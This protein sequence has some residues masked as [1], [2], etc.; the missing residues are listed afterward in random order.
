MQTVCSFALNKSASLRQAA[1]YGIGV[2]AT[3]GGHAFAAQAE[4]CLTALKTAVEY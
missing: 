1:A 2:I 3:H 4:N